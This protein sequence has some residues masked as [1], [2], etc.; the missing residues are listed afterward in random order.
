VDAQEPSRHAPDSQEPV[1]IASLANDDRGVQPG[2]PWATRVVIS[3]VLLLVFGPILYAWLPHEVAAWYAAAAFEKRLDGDFDGAFATL[4]RAMAWDADDS[5][6]YGLRGEWRL[7]RKQYTEALEDFRRVLELEP[8]KR[9][10]AVLIQRTQALQR[11]GRHDEAIAEWKRLGK[12]H[13]GDNAA[14]RATMLNGLAYAMA[15][16]KTDLDQALE[17]I[18]Q[19]LRL[20]G[21][22]GA[23]LDTRGFIHLLRGDLEK[24]KFDL[25]LA[26]ALVEQQLGKA[27]KA[28]EYI[29]RR[30][31][32]LA[33]HQEQEGVA[34]IRYHR[35]L[36]YD[37]L[38]QPDQ[39]NADRQRVR[40]LGFEPNDD[41]F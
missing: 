14:T 36:V 17:P 5:S 18:E 9:N 30:E 33:L 40:D 7:T 41:L 34:V 20:V 25:D 8:G 27:Q 28:D 21:N 2:R 29:D 31:Y 24:A 26:V 39:A 38:G 19:A 22:N 1:I 13:Q 3:I 4:D 23:M 10:S 16:G 11:L 37:K 35:A 12:L 6:L 32:L 15:V